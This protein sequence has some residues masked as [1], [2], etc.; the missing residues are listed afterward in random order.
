MAP[1]AG[2]RDITR[3]ID[4]DEAF[5]DTPGQLHELLAEGLD[6][7]PY[8]GKNLDAL[9]DCLEDLD[10]STHIRIVRDAPTRRLPWLDG[11]CRV[12]K[13]CAHEN[14]FLEFELDEGARSDAAM[15][16]ATLDDVL[17]RLERI[18]G[19]LDALQ[20]AAPPAPAPALAGKPSAQTC[21]NTASGSDGDRFAC[22]SCGCRVSDYL[23]DTRMLI[24]GLRFCPN[25][26]CEVVNPEGS[27]ALGWVGELI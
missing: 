11:F 5:L 27:N 1:N 7:P 17:A 10:V 25:C 16:H 3:R 8:Y 12:V 19:R 20:P 18:E 26:G 13:R 2:E 4:I 6:F 24:D 14:P 23:E 15:P 21:K 22:G 9:S